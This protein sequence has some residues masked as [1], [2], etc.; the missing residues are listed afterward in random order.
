L[1]K[2]FYFPPSD[3]FYDIHIT[4]SIVEPNL[5]IITACAPALRPLFKHYFPTVFGSLSRSENK[6]STA[7]TRDKSAPNNIGYALEQY[8]KKGFR[9]DGHEEL[10]S[11]ASSEKEFA[12]V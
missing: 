10:S 2:L 8:G 9:K 1:V 6:S 7:H 5:A 3:P 4:M 11:I 12:R